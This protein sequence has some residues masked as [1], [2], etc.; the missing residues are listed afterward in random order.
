MASLAVYLTTLFL[1]PQLAANTADHNK[2][3]TIGHG[4]D[5]RVTRLRP[6]AVT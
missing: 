2:T 5:T 3:A 6:T 4:G 1:S